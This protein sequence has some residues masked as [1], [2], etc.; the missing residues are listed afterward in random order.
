MSRNIVASFTPGIW[1]LPL[2]QNINVGPHFADPGMT[3]G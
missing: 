3:E 2:A 1:S